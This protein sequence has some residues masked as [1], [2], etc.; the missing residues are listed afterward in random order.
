MAKINAGVIS[1][2]EI[3]NQRG[4]EDYLFNKRLKLTSKDCERRYFYKKWLSRYKLSFSEKFPFDIDA[5]FEEH[6]KKDWFTVGHSYNTAKE[7]AKALALRFIKSF[8]SRNFT[9]L[10][11]DK[12]VSIDYGPNREWRGVGFYAVADTVD[13]VCRDNIDGKIHLIKV[14][15][16]MPYSMRARS[17]E[18]KP[19]NSPELI[20]MKASTIKEYPDAVCELWSLKAS[21]DSGMV[22][23][24]T[25]DVVSC[26]FDGFESEEALKLLLLDV[27]AM[28][29]KCTSC[30]NCRF[31]EYCKT[32][33]YKKVE[34][35]KE[36]AKTNSYTIV[37]SEAQRELIDHLDGPMSV[38][39]IP[40]AGKTASL[41]ERCRV[42][43]QEKDINPRN[44]LLVSFTKKAC[45]ELKARLSLT[46]TGDIPDVMTLNAFGNDVIVSN[47]GVIGRRLKLASESDCKEL[48]EGLMD[49]LPIFK[50]MSYD[51]LNTKFGLVSQLYNWFNEIDKVG[52]EIFSENH[53]NKDTEYIEMFYHVYK[54]EYNRLGYIS[55]D[56][57][58]ERALDMLKTNE[59]L[60]FMMS[61]KYRYIMVDEYQDINDAQAE[62]IDVIAR[63]HGNL[64]VVG[65]DDQSIYGWR[66]G[67][68]KY[69]INFEDRY[70]AAKQTVFCDNYRSTDKILGACQQL[71]G[72]N[73]T[74]IEKVFVSHK[75]GANKPCLFKNFTVDAIP[76]IVRMANKAGFNNGDIAVIART[77]KSIDAITKVLNNENIASISP[78]DF[79]INNP[80]WLAIRDLLSI[81][82][83]GIED[84]PLYRLLRTLGASP[85]AFIKMHNYKDKSLYE[86]LVGE[87]YMF[88]LDSESWNGYVNK[89]AS[90]EFEELIF[91]V[92]NAAFKVYNAMNIVTGRRVKAVVPAISKVLFGTDEHPAVLE[93]LNQAE[94]R[95][96]S[97]IVNL[98]NFMNSA[99]R[100]KAT[101]SMEC[102]INPEAVNLMTAHASKGKEF[103]FVL[104]YG[105]EEFTD[106]EESV[107]LLFVAMSR[108]KK[109]LFLTEGP[110]GYSVLLPAIRNNIQVREY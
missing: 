83:N 10:S 94:E 32:S 5:I 67:S 103:P 57:Q 109:S 53:K 79:I 23:S 6:F 95:G 68:N 25:L 30:D 1:P 60:A 65:D 4:C 98:L 7:K 56:D 87:N 34:S 90:N 58:I 41:V 9:I 89:E 51:G 97:D 20:V 101:D 40:G 19:I 2:K 36:E 37:Y 69:L 78:R 84:V 21:K 93:L 27:M 16:S 47:S 102:P 104:V 61:R 33:A 106:D 50:G 63:H 82:I 73:E 92:S 42:M 62:L 17:Q 108:A 18:N 80:V 3:I 86:Q 77:N 31:A 13:F 12:K 105:I 22:L 81:S 85:Y 35:Y 64:V 59:R 48:I 15:S 54:K 70:P 91:G 44:I 71:I 99:I 29:V 38:L 43:I 28:S 39:A 49:K 74:R 107:R 11:Y 110:S 45:E 8:E 52:F 75:E 72:K 96:I 14:V 100:F 76:N 55:Y 24:D 88:S 66:G 46:L 26:T